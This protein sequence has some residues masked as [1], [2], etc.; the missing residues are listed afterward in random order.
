VALLAGC[1]PLVRAQTFVARL[2]GEEKVVT[3]GAFACSNE[4]EITIRLVSV[5]GDT[6]VVVPLGTRNPRADSLPIGYNGVRVAYMSTKGG[7]VVPD[8]GFLLLQGMQDRVIH[9]LLT[10]TSTG[11]PIGSLAFR[12]LYLGEEPSGSLTCTLADKTKYVRA[13]GWPKRFAAAVIDGRILIGMSRPMVI[14]VVGQPTRKVRTETAD[15]VSER[16]FYGPIDFIEF[17]DGRVSLIQ[18]SR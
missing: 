14:Q 8:G 12:A 18:D 4:R 15:G 5:S 7:F 6:S 11:A 17:R 13:R 2:Q 10:M 3:G 9:G 1:A 16:W